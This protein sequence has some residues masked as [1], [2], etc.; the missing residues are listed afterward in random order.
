MAQATTL[1]R[2][3]Y[4]RNTTHAVGQGGTFPCQ[5]TQQ[6]HPTTLT[7]AQIMLHVL[8]SGSRGWNWHL[9]HP[10]LQ[11]CPSKAHTQLHGPPTTTH[12]NT[13]ITTAALGVVKKKQWTWNTSCSAA[14][15]PRDN[16]GT[17][18]QQEKQTMVTQWWH[19]GGDYVIKHHVPFPHWATSPQ[20]LTPI[21]FL[22]RHFEIYK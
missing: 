16:L 20:F 5:T 2:H 10:F 21:T 7:I 8:G 22:R 19:N 3:I 14:G 11:N 13:N 4:Q 17:T 6:F 1:T 18:V 9:V 15:K 12:T